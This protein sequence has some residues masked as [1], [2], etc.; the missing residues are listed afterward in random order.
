MQLTPTIHQRKFL[1][2][3]IVKLVLKRLLKNVFNYILLV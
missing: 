3:K 2:L 1:I